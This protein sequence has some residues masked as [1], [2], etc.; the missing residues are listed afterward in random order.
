M[1]DCRTDQYFSENFLVVGGA[2][3]ASSS[4][5]AVWEYLSSDN[6][7]LYKDWL[8][9]NGLLANKGTWE[10]LDDRGWLLYKD[11][12]AFNEASILSPAPSGGGGG[13]ARQ[14]I[15]KPVVDDA[16]EIF[17]MITNAFMIM[18]KEK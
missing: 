10:S 18:Q 2:N 17:L 11:W 1:Y 3:I 7:L 5:V 4:Q 14:L 9:T 13:Y 6:W 8:A 12:L 15:Y 16:E